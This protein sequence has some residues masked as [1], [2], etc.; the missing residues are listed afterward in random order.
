LQDQPRADREGA[1]GRASPTSRRALLNRP[2]GSAS[3]AS[4]PVV[5]TESLS[6]PICPTGHRST[7]PQ[8]SPRHEVCQRPR[9]AS[10]QSNVGAALTGE[11]RWFSRTRLH[12]A[13]A[14]GESTSPLFRTGSPRLRSSDHV[15]QLPR[16]LVEGRGCCPP[17]CHAYLCHRDHPGMPLRQRSRRSPICAFLPTSSKRN[18]FAQIH[19]EVEPTTRVKAMVAFCRT[20]PLVSPF[21]VFEHVRGASVPDL[22]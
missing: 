16:L 10:C 8:A 14:R 18:V 3:W 22:R 1:A 11:T 15:I 13:S 21:L 20:Y 17:R 4:G 19:F 2:L 9:A 12:H 5:R 6:G 7:L